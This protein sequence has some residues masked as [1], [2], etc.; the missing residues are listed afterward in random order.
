MSKRKS[1]FFANETF[2]VDKRATCSKKQLE[3]LTNA[4]QRHGGTLTKDLNSSVTYAILPPDDSKA[5][6]AKIRY[7]V[8]FRHLYPYYKANGIGCRVSLSNGYK[9]ALHL[10]GF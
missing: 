1:P 6:G 5:D 9:I 2:Y 4:I 3:I 10:V 8:S 7:N